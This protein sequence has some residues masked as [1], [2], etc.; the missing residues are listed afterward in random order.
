MSTWNLNHNIS[1]TWNRGSRGDLIIRRTSVLPYL[2]FKQ[3]IQLIRFPWWMVNYGSL[4][5]SLTSIDVRYSNQM[6]WEHSWVGTMGLCCQNEWL[7]SIMLVPSHLPGYCPKQCISLPYVIAWIIFIYEIWN[8]VI[9]IV[10]PSQL[11]NWLTIIA[12]LDIFNFNSF[13][14]EGKMIMC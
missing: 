8:K 7:L 10:R 6:W 9:F 2:P 14:W 12:H 4:M 13:K 11:T 1:H 3:I 5:W